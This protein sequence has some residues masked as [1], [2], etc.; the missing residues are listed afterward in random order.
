MRPWPSGSAS[1]APA[2]AKWTKLCRA[3][4]VRGRLRISA[5][6]W[7]HSPDGNTAMH[8]SSH[9]VTT[10]PSL[11]RGRNFAGIASRPFSSNAWANSPAK[12][13]SNHSSD[14]GI[15]W[16]PTSPHYSPRGGTFTPRR[17]RVKWFPAELQGETRLR[18]ASNACS[19]HAPDAPSP[20]CIQERSQTGLPRAR[21]EPTLH[22]RAAEK[23]R[24]GHRD[25]DDQRGEHEESFAE[26][27]IRLADGSRA[28][29]DDRGD[30]EQRDGAG[31][32]DGCEH[33]ALRAGR[34][35]IAA[36]DRCDAGA[37]HDRRHRPSRC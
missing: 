25:R 23:R 32:Q 6:I 30:E 19:N 4:S 22:A 12:L 11:K 37:G 9:R 10:A 24:A 33:G 16:F 34:G 3:R 36:G 20:G 28:R 8:S 7:P 5:L 1:C 14:T 15:G 13:V 26:Q 29:G 21:L 27:S 35:V 18:R 17:A 31:D 2:T